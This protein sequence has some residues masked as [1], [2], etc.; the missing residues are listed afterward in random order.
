MLRAQLAVL[1][2]EFEDGDMSPEE[3]EP[4]RGRAARPA[5]CCTGRPRTERSK[6]AHSWMTQPR[7]PSR[8]L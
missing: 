6:V 3:F 1:N 8:P 2:R 5:A 4:G 7:W